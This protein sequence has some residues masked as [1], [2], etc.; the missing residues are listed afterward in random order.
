MEWASIG[1]AIRLKEEDVEKGYLL[2]V[3]VNGGGEAPIP[4][5][6]FGR[7]I[8]GMRQYDWL[9]LAPLSSRCHRRY[10]FLGIR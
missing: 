10:R 8:G 5:V 9:W 7:L 3:W 6:P 4:V 2:L 1:V